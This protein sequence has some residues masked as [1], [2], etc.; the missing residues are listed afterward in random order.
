MSGTAA[1]L[2]PPAPPPPVLQTTPDKV[3]VKGTE[4]ERNDEDPQ[5]ELRRAVKLL[6]NRLPENE[7]LLLSCYKVIQSQLQDGP[8]CG[9]Y[10]LSMASQ[11]VGIPVPVEKLYEHAKAKQYT[12]Q[13]EMFSAANVKTLAEDL[14]NCKCELLSTGMSDRAGI[15]SHLARGHPLLVP[16]DSDGNFEPGLKRGH[17]AHWGAVTGFL[18]ILPKH[19]LEKVKMICNQDNDLHYLYHV[20]AAND[21]SDLLQ[22]LISQTCVKNTYLYAKQGKSRHL[23]L[24]MYQETVDSNANL[25]EVGPERE[26]GDYIFPAGGVGEGLCNQV[27][28]LTKKEN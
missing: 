11:C 13:G 5:S 12:I 24:W 2:P 25:Q 22:S 19:D 26:G 28:L 23:M 14:C 10:A 1:I 8:M 21:N 3:V 16:Y 18:F 17:K 15:L 7:D 4:R 6:K 27:L 20:D 9:L